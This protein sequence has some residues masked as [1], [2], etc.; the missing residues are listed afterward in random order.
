MLSVEYRLCNARSHRFHV[1]TAYLLYYLAIIWTRYWHLRAIFCILSSIGRRYRGC[2]I[3]FDLGWSMF[4]DASDLD[5]WIAL[6]T[7]IN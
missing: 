2:K 7:F 5:C 3:P 6:A 4:L 1:L